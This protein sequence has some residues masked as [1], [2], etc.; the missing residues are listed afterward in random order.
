MQL[1]FES[2]R[3]KEETPEQPQDRSEEGTYKGS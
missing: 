2:S 3:N 1:Q